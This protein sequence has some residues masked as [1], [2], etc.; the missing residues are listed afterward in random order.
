MKL[1]LRDEQG[2]QFLHFDQE[3]M[4]QRGTGRTRRTYPGAL[5]VVR[6]SKQDLGWVVNWH[7]SN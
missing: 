7:K 4:P 5:R 6:N 2:G 1:R 3:T